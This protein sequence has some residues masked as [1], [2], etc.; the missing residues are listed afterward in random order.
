MLVLVDGLE[1][2]Q[3]FH[4]PEMFSLLSVVDAKAVDD[5]QFNSGG[6][7]VDYGNRMSGVID[8]TSSNSGP[9]RTS[10]AIS[11][12]EIGLL[13]EGS[14]AG[15]RGRWLLSARRTD[16]DR[17]IE[18]VDPGNGL[19]PDFFDVLAKLSYAIG[20]QTTVS[21]NVLIAE[22]NTHYTEENGRVEEMLDADLKNQN[23]WLN[24]KTAWTPRFFSQTVLSA[25]NVAGKRGGFI[26]YWNQEGFIDDARSLDFYGLR[27]DWSLDIGERH[28]LKW[29]FDI[30][31]LSRP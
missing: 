27:Q 15:G 29:G 4:M 22:D 6:F 14:F 19:E 5:L 18:W 20:D 8:I 26:D 2:Y 3:A 31:R 21:A 30:R 11:T 7:A 13:S 23:V 16:L 25:G 17:V 28:M 24:L 1:V 12:T 10:F 9:A